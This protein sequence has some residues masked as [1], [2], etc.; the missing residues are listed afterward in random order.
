MVTVTHYAQLNGFVTKDGSEIRELMHPSTHANT[1]QSVAEAI[2]PPG[3]STL[4]HRHLLSEEIYY[5]V[6]G[7]GEMVLGLE[8]FGVNAGDTV[9]IPPNT[10]HKLINLNEAP[11]KLL[12]CSA[13]AYADDDTQIL[14]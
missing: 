7:R 1:G 6:S 10:P 2:V 13:P 11:L 12:C 8:R 5:F 3:A 4:M 14:E 9:L